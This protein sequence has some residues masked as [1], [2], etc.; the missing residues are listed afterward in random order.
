MNNLEQHLKEQTDAFLIDCFNEIEEWGKSRVLG[1][2]EVRN[3]YESF[4]LN[5]TQLH[6]ISQVIYKEMASRFVE[7]KVD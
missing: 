6:M 3:L 2:G 1:Q 7:S 5:I 4:N